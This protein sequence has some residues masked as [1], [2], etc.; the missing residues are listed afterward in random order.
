M[1]TKFR[2]GALMCAFFFAHVLSAFGQGSLTPPGT[3]APTMKSLDQIEP[4]KE[5]NATNTPG[6][7]GTLFDISAPGSYYLG[8]N[9]TGVSGKSGIRIIA[10]NVTI[11]LNGF[12]LA[13]VAGTTQGILVPG[14]LTNIVIRN[15][16][17]ANW[18]GI[19]IS[20][21]FAQNSH[22]HQLQIR[23]NGS[24]GLTVGIAARVTECGAFGNAGNG[25]SAAP[26]SVIS[27]CTAA[28]NSGNGIVSA[29]P[30]ITAIG[31]TASH[32]SGVGIFVFSSLLTDCVASGNGDRGIVTGDGSTLTNCV[33][34]QN[35]G[36]AGIVAG[37][38]STLS[39]CTAYTNTGDGISAGAGS[40]LANCTANDNLGTNGI[41]AGAG[42]N[43]NNCTAYSNDVEFGIFVEL[44][45]TLTNCTASENN[46]A[47]AA[48]WGISAGAQCTISNC[49]ASGNLNTNGAPTATT[50]GG[51]LA[52]ASS[53]IQNCT[54][55]GNKG[56]GI[57]FP[58]DARVVGNNC[59]SNGLGAGDGAGI[60]ATDGD[61]RIEGNNVTDNDR[62][63]DVDAAGNLIIKNSASG[64][65]TNNYDIAASNRYG[66]IVDITAV[67]TAAVSGN[68]AADTTTTT[69]PWA[70][71]AY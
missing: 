48:S 41:A 1:K 42:S 26:D 62:G 45:S 31:C 12:A 53:T 43:L 46:S 20:A 13:G 37:I 40:T 49:A 24:T 21:D 9:I 32:N 38:G 58:N 67:G 8:G 59:D 52:G 22:F 64:N 5:V 14:T 60:H 28:T 39:H 4:R 29:G 63:I 65:T 15:G 71:F 11:D 3:P 30:G 34:Y 18:G 10:D 61:A 66:P 68:N 55:A 36:I 33:A 27:H 47:A 70:N 25:I 23:S 35:A 57:Q 19:G 54:V 69:H 16:T 17:V 51:I 56:D 7:A 44:R 6:N 2:S 50:G